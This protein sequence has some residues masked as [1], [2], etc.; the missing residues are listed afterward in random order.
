LHYPARPLKTP[1][2][3]RN[4]R[5]PARGNIHVSIGFPFSIHSVSRSVF[6]GLVWVGLL[7]ALAAQPELTCGLEKSGGVHQSSDGVVDLKWSGDLTTYELEAAT[8]GD[9]FEPRY[10][11]ADLSSVRTGLEE[12]VHRFR[13]RGIN[14]EGDAG[15]WSNV[16]S[17]E[18]SY[19]ESGRVRLLLGLG[20]FVVL[21][22]ILA[23]LHGHFTHR[24]KE[25]QA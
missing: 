16:L 13:V 20:G 19:M 9:L 25:G 22:T 8:P 23:I 3:H 17:V 7:G 4:R 2:V 10:L 21:A 18:V 12:G 11:G 14:A 24:V 6:A 1:P 15:P 5:S